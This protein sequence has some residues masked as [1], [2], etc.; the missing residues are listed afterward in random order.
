MTLAPLPTTEPAELP[1]S[2]D[3]IA[4]MAQAVHNHLIA[5]GVGAG[6]V[7][8]GAGGVGTGGNG[9][10]ATREAI[11]EFL[12][13]RQPRLSQQLCHEIAN[14][15][16]ALAT[17]LGPLQPLME[18]D[19]TTEIMIN[20]PGVV[21]VERAGQ[22]QPTEIAVTPS[23]I[24]HIIERIVA[25]LGLHIDRRQ[26]FGDARLPDGTRVNIVIAPLAIDGPYVTIRR[27]RAQQFPLEAFCDDDAEVAAEVAGQ[28]RQL[29]LDKAN[30]VVSGGTGSGKTSLLNALASAIPAG[31]RIVTIEDAAE[32]RLASQH[33]VRLETRAANPDG[34]GAIDARSLLRNA[35]RMRPDRIIVG[36]VRGSEVFEMLQAMNV[37]HQGS[38]SSCHANS[39]ADTFSR[40]EMMAL[41]YNQGLP[42][43]AVRRQLESAVDAVIYMTRTDGGKRKVAEVVRGVGGRNDGGRDSGRGRDDVDRRDNAG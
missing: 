14:R 11:T 27:F 35:L 6:G 18:D 2:E 24:E 21:M 23:D 1:L 17:G 16:L 38:M 3:K 12:R 19:L 30:I 9:S 15:V 7:G 40:L 34:V 42:I 31:E 33:V 32:L 22:I 4:A 5:G 25:P 10:G 37:G 36:E 41:L 29:V 13:A 26:P 28:L 20:G 8:A 43:E 39:V